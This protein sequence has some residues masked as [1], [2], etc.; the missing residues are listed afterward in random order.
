MTWCK[1]MDLLWDW[2]EECV[3]NEQYEKAKAI[4]KARA[5]MIIERMKFMDKLI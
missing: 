5:N 3:D 2:S 4:R 1:D